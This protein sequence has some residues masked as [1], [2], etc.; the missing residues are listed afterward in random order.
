MIYM[1]RAELF[2]SVLAASFV[3]GA[4][5]NAIYAEVSGRTGVSPL[6]DGTFE[7][8]VQTC[9]IGVDTLRVAGPND[10]GRNEVYG[11]WKAEDPVT[12]AFVFN[13]LSPPEGWQG[14]QA[15]SLPSA[16]DS[17]LLIGVGSSTAD[18]QVYPVDVRIAEILENEPSVII[19]GSEDS[20]HPAAERK[21]LSREEFDKCPG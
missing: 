5:G 4:C 17:L 13:P 3:L 16:P 10:G 12:G 14:I 18:A 11:E 1:K 21:L 6:G 7:I 8:Y 2:V 15:L 20:T 9:G 19:T